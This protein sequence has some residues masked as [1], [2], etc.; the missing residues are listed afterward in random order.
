MPRRKGPEAETDAAKARESRWRYLLRNPKFREELNELRRYYREGIGRPTYDLETTETRPKREAL[1]EKW[2]LIGIPNEIR[3]PYWNLPDLSPQS[4]E[5]YESYFEREA[6]ESSIGDIV[7]AGDP[8]EMYG[9]GEYG[10]ITYPDP[11]PGP[12]LFL[13]LRVDLRHPL[14]LLISLIN[15]ELSK[16]IQKRP[17]PRRRRRLDKVDFYLKVYDLAEKGKT[18]RGIAKTLKRP[19]ST[20]KSAYATACKN[21]YGLNAKPSKK[22]LPMAT[23]DWKNFDP[24]AHFKKCRECK[25]AK[26]PDAM[27]PPL[28]LYVKQ[29]QQGQRV[30]TGYDTRR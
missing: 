9:W 11:G 20:V 13:E 22:P 30:I 16:A 29:D 27:C 26:T 10:G 7:S 4:I 25:T 1:N 8:W 6:A 21:I 3:H 28:R 17:R 24:E 23:F 14:D 15:Q 12:G 19:D 18:F 2:E 5:L